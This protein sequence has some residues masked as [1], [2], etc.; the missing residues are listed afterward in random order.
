M[1]YLLAAQ[2]FGVGLLIAFH[3]SMNSAVGSVVQNPRMGNAVFWVI[4]A[5]AAVLIGLTGWDSSVWMRLR[6]VPVWLWG[7][8]AIGATMVFVIVA[9]IPKLGAA[10]TN[11]ALLTGQVIGGM[12]I[13]HYG[14][15]GSPVEC[16]NGTRVAGAI[17]SLLG[18]ALVVLGR[19]PLLR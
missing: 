11:I 13:G 5:L 10:S 3:F 4:G 12:I 1:R 9:T 16:C 17:I 14:L 7:A 19:V 6:E 2:I 8:G 15:L 18:A